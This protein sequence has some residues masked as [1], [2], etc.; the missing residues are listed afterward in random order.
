MAPCLKDLGQEALRQRSQKQAAGKQ[1]SCVRTCVATCQLHTQWLV[2]SRRPPA[3][4]AAK[5]ASL[6]AV[7]VFAGAAVTVFAGC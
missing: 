2:T 6:T 7:T 4:A 5:K 3:L 1:T